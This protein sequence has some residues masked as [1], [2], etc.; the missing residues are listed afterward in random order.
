MTGQYT[1]TFS[2]D[3]LNCMDVLYCPPPFASGNITHP[4]NSMYLGKIFLYI[5]LNHMEYLY[6]ILITIVRLTSI[7]VKKKILKNPVFKSTFV[8]LDIY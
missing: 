2:H 4:C 3:T 8:P 6:I 7:N 1:R 5:D